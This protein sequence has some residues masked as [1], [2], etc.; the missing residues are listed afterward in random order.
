MGVDWRLARSLVTLRRQIDELAPGR[1]IRS[2]G[3]VGDTS[4]SRR[5]SDHNPD[6]NG[7]VK[8]LDITHDPRGGV[9]IQVLADKVAASKDSRIRYIICNGRIMGGKGGPKPWVWRVYDGVNP[10]DKH[11]HFSVIGGKLADDAREWGIT[12]PLTKAA[13]PPGR[14]P[15]ELI[16]YPTL[17]VGY[18]GHPALM[19]QYA[20]IRHGAKIK[21][22]SDFGPKT[23]AAV[24]A[25]QKVH[26]LVPDGIVG[27]YTWDAL[28][29]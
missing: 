24:K 16:D 23:L 14:A 13:P 7:L 29:T 25:F 27:P 9:D 17:R 22:D 8:A 21:A 2:D 10:H 26:K 6:G 18:Q 11:V 1:S 5:K 28:L 3:T 15:D 12:G 19:L 4:H 20:L